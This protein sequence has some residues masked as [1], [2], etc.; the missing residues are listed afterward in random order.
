MKGIDTLTSSGG[1][2]IGGLAERLGHVPTDRLELRAAVLAELV[3]EGLQGGRILALLGPDHGTLTVVIGNHS[4]VAVP[5]ATGD[6]VDADPVET[7]EAGGVQ[8]IGDHVDHVLGHRLPADPQQLGD[9]GLVHALGHVGDQVL[10]VTGV[11]SA[12]PG[13]G[14]CLGAIR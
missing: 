7:L 6:L 10:E 5:L 1:P 13:P 14:H 2:G 3:V 4:E 9:R 11:T 8:A 12:W